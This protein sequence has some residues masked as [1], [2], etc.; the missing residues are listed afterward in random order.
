M[1]DRPRALIILIAV[2]LLGCI[3]G[4][5]GAYIWSKKSLD[6]RA[7]MMGSGP[8][9]RGQGRQRMTDLLKLT[10][11]QESRFREIMAESRRKL[12]ELQ[13]EQIP[14]IEAI[15]IETNRKFSETLNEEQ[16]KKFEAFLKQWQDRGDRPPRGRDS[17]LPPR[18]RGL[19]PPPPPPPP[20]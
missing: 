6:F 18:N 12:G 20:Q 15:R 4:T 19:G 16:R 5:I 7:P 13:K 8:Q 2:F 17:E 3:T 9:V 14:K 1:T 11:E 10:P